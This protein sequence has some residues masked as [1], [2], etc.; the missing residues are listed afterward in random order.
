MVNIGGK[1]RQVKFTTNAL[2]ELAEE[3]GVDIL[4]GFNPSPKNVR[5]VC[6]VGLKYGALS[7]KQV[8]DFKPE[9]VGDWLNTDDGSMTEGGAMGQIFNVLIKQ[10]GPKS[11]GGE[12]KGELP[13]TH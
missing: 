12:A 6:Y 3:F 5:S 9:D 11:E 10:G 7:D 13:G 1:D 4:K 8:V 2:I